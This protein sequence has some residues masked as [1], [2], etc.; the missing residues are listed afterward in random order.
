M[1]A[2][3]IF[4]ERFSVATEDT[5]LFQYLWCRHIR[6]MTQ[7]E[8][9]MHSVNPRGNAVRLVCYPHM[10]IGKVWIYRLL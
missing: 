9:G 2:F 4:A 1:C 7:A 5:P 8:M 10:P 6:S 3:F